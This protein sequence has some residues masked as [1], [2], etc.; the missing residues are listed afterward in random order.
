MAMSA[1]STRGLGAEPADAAD[2][3]A[4]C[5]TSSSAAPHTRARALNRME[6]TMV[7]L[8]AAAR[9]WGDAER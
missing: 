5:S 8:Q 2:P 3:D 1:L 6:R 7:V 9:E 4:T